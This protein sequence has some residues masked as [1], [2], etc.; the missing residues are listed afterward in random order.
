MKNIEPSCLFHLKRG[1]EIDG[2]KLKSVI[3][4]Y[5]IALVHVDF[6]DP[7]GLIMQ[8]IADDIGVINN[9]NVNSD[10]GLWHIKI[11]E[12]ATDD[13]GQLIRSYTD[14]EF[15]MHTDCSYEDDPPRLFSLFV[16]QKDRLGG[17]KNRLVRSADL[18]KKL[19]PA[20]VEILRKT[21]FTIRVPPGFKKYKESVTGPIL[22]GKDL[23]RYRRDCVIDEHCTPDQLR[24][25]FELEEALVN[26][27]IVTDLYLDNGTLLILDNARFLHA[28][29]KIL[30]RDRH[31]LR[32]RFYPKDN[33]LPFCEW[34]V[35]DKN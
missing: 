5:G 17:G 21:N 18:L 35:E 10:S 13:S 9:H 24:A 30:D 16:L 12:E 3:A 15:P 14:A 19:S 25:I 20:T 26:N 29:D 32:M 4:E 11:N 34:K 27:E 23:F 28:R 31:L 1:E 22:T 7:E 2:V 33:W 6:A 8:K